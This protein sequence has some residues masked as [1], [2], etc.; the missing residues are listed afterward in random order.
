[1]SYAEDIPQKNREIYENA[2]DFPCHF[3]FHLSN[4]TCFGFPFLEKFPAGLLQYWPWILYF[5]F[6]DD[7]LVV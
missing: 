6:L 1:M 3:Q 5:D 2:H 7:R 4:F